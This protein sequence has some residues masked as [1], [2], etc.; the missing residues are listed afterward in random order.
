MIN[1][2]ILAVLVAVNLQCKSPWV[3]SG[4]YTTLAFILSLVF[5]VPILTVILTAFINLG[6]TYLYFWLLKKFEGSSYWWLIM[7]VGILLFLGISFS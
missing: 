4:I 6:L 5:G 2:L 3:A 7:I 1:A